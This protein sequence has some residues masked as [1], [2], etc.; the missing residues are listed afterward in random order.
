MTDLKDE[1]WDKITRKKSLN[2]SKVRSLSSPPASLSA[3]QPQLAAPV[4]SFLGALQD[5]VGP[6]NSELLLEAE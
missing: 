2:W 5:H 6:D 1:Y 4:N 3:S